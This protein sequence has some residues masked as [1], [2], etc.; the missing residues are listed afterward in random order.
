MDFD[1]VN[2]L[3]ELKKQRTIVGDGELPLLRGAS[4]APLDRENIHEYRRFLKANTEA[5]QA[6]QRGMTPEEI[7]AAEEQY[8][9]WFRSYLNE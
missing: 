2:R 1:K 7:K 3:V 9:V 5:Q 4:E 6:V 8:L